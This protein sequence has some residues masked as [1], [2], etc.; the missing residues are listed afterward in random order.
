MT[1]AC[2]DGFGKSVMGL[3]RY[4]QSRDWRASHVRLLCK[5]ARAAG[6]HLDTT[7]LEKAVTAAY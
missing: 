7:L 2:K 6:M 4:Q 3:P 5:W 1:W